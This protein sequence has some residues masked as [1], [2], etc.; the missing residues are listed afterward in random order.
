MKK[1][2]FPSAQTV[3]LIIAAFVALLTW[4]IPSGQYDRLAYN[5]EDN[6]FI[7]TSKE[8]S[9]TLEAS[10]KTL[11]DLQ[12]KIPIEKFTSGAIYKPISIPG[13]YQK[14]EAKP[15]GFKAFILSPLKGIIQVADIIILVL[16]IGGLV[17]IVNFT[18]AFEAGIT[19]LS[20][21]LKGREYLLIIIVTTLIA[22]G[23]TTFGLAEETIAFYPILIPIF[24]AAKYDAIVALACI[25]IGSS[26]GTMIST[27]NPFSTIIASNSAGINWTTGIEGR[28]LMLFIGL[29]IC[30]LY[31]IR[32]AQ[33]VK[34]DPT[35]SIIFDQKESIEKMFS[36]KKSIETINFTLQLKLVL[37]IFI[38]CFVVMVYGVSNLDWWFLEMTGVFFVGALLIGFICRINETV[39]VDVFIKGASELL[40]VAFIIGLARGVTVLMEDGLISDTLLYYSSSLTE[41]MNKGFFI[42]SMLFVYSGL[43]FFIPSSSGMAVLT[44]PI[45]SPLADTVSL[46]REH[47]VN[48]YLLG[49]GLFNFINPTGLILASLAIVK[50]GY[51]KWLK[52]V[53]PLVIILT[54]VSMI[55]LTISVYI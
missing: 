50:V 28:V 35:K 7:K 10:Q 5:K 38:L 47:V 26:I 21:L 30:I 3:L 25:Y 22:L 44:M 45:M 18:G 11:N 4:L 42:N 27:I 51:D 53:I 49:M 46:G 29:I 2:K 23:G 52:F 9:I 15:Q 43:T 36:F 12:V 55:F 33:R 34:K 41:G 1:R 6:T 39:F 13:T 20:K 14:L 32:Y 24:I 48:A 17:A 19:R 8:N 40:S 37:T 54:I 31:I 16:F